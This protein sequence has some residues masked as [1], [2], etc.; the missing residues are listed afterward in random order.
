AVRFIFLNRT[1]FNGIYRVNKKG[2]YNV[3]F[4]KPNPAFS[5]LKNLRDVSAKLQSAELS[6]DYYDSIENLTQ[7]GDLIYLDSPY[8][9]LSNTAY[10]NHYTL[11]KFDQSSQ[12]ELAAFANNQSQ[13]GCKVVISNADLD[14]IRELYNN[15]QIIECSAYRFISCKK[16]KIKV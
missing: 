4:G 9:K 15:W 14:V 2:K 3:P 1:S 6:Y 12:E 13:K 10:F 11:D 16:E 7:E 5:S 8:P